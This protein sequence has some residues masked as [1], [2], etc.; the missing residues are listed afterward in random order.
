MDKVTLNKFITLSITMRDGINVPLAS[1]AMWANSEKDVCNQI[2]KAVSIL[3]FSGKELI[4]D[5]EDI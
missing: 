2:K 3:N 5:V 1:F 4:V